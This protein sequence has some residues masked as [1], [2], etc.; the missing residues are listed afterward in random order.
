M[1]KSNMQANDMAR[2]VN[3]WETPGVSNPGATGASS[4][5]KKNGWRLE[6]ALT[7]MLVIVLYNS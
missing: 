4:T 5:C 6:T 3:N 7:M 1:A 2:T